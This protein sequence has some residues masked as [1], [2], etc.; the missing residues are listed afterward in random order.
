MTFSFRYQ[1]VLEQRRHAE[2][3]RQ[4][5]L[6]D[7]L[8]QRRELEDLLREAQQTITTNKQQLADSLT[9]RVDMSQL[10]M[11]ARY[12]SHT[13][14]RGMGVVRRI[15]RLDRDIEAARARLLEATRQV[16]ALELLRDREH[17]QWKKDRR[18][19]EDQRLDEVAV[20]RYARTRTRPTLRLH[21]D[22]PEGVNP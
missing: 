18:K 19:K 2:E 3:Q 14:A 8:R 16:K 12:A 7:V 17:E 11:F 15:A 6:A 22:E 20:Q 13:T 10:G 9:G 5:E 21:R 1:S 4:R